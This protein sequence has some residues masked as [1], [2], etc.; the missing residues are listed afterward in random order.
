MLWGVGGGFCDKISFPRTRG[1][2][3]MQIGGGKSGQLKG[4]VAI[5]RWSPAK[6]LAGRDR[7]TETI[8]GETPRRSAGIFQE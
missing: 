4:R 2:P 1:M 5:E 3:P 8:K 6:Q 7:A